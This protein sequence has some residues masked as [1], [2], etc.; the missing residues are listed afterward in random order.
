MVVTG[1]INP[2]E[3]RRE[4]TR[5]QGWRVSGPNSSNSSSLKK[6][7]NP[8][9]DVGCRMRERVFENYRLRAFLREF[10]ARLCYW[11]QPRPPSTL[12]WLCV[13]TRFNPSSL[14]SF[15]L[16]SP[17]LFSPFLPLSHVLYRSTSP[18]HL[19]PHQNER[20][21]PS[22]FSFHPPGSF[23]PFFSHGIVLHLFL[24]LSLSPFLR[25]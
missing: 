4:G 12:L 3:C 7:R 25:D 10:G 2:L 5:R 1:S 11:G 8:S 16:R 18:H 19:H 9:V 15:C 20:D 6:K 17:L 23:P 21:N 13:P 22:L 14:P 24:F